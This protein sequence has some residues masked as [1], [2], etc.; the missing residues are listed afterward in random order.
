[1]SGSARSKTANLPNSSQKITG[2]FYS[3][4]NNTEA[5]IHDAPAPENGV[6]TAGVDL[7]DKNFLIGLSM[8]SAAKNI[9]KSFDFVVDPYPTAPKIE[10]DTMLTFSIDIGKEVKR[11]SVKVVICNGSE[12]EEFPLDSLKSDAFEHKFEQ[13]NVESYVWIFGESEGAPFS[14]KVA[15]PVE[16]M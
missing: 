6:A 1:M 2:E 16:G 13:A 8:F 3:V 7:K 11:D 14:Y 15:I 4:E 5:R 10:K 9:N 12:K